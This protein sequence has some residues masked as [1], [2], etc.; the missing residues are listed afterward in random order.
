MEIYNI[1]INMLFFKLLCLKL[2]KHL[3][4]FLINQ[5]Y[6]LLTSKYYMYFLVINKHHIIWFM[7]YSYFP[8]LQKNIQLDLIF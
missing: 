1:I 2:D 8:N 3:N 5:T 4:Q 7:I 6:S